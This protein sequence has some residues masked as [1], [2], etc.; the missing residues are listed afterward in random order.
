M[1]LSCRAKDRHHLS[2]L[3]IGSESTSAAFLISTW[4]S[5][6]SDP[7]TITNDSTDSPT[8]SNKPS[9]M[10]FFLDGCVVAT[11]R[12]GRRLGAT[13]AEYVNLQ[14][15]ELSARA[16]PGRQSNAQPLVKTRSIQPLSMAD[17]PHQYQGNTRTRVWA[18]STGGSDPVAQRLAVHVQLLRHRGDR[19]A[20]LIRLTAKSLNSAVYTLR[21]IFIFCPSKATSMLRHPRKTK[22][23]GKLILTI[24]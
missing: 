3:T 11:P 18:N 19:L 12:E 16:C 1:A 15:L 6:D 10:F 23:Q 9:E 8:Y 17:I 7:P 14:T 2:S 13:H 20:G 4:C 24:P 21:A 5:G 22:F